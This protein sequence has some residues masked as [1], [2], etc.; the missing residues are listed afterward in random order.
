MEVEIKLS[1][2][3]LQKISLDFRTVANRLIRTRHEDGISNLKRFI[4]H[5]DSNPII[6]KFIQQHNSHQFNIESI[7]SNYPYLN[8]PIGILFDF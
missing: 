8:N 2:Q 1:K 7:I 6:N 4:K 5:L 3:E